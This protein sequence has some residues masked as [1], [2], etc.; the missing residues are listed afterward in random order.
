MA[1]NYAKFGYGQKGN[2]NT[3]LSNGKIDGCDVVIA[4]DTAEIVFIRSD[5]SQYTLRSRIKC[6][7]NIVEALNQLNSASDT[8]A[9]QPV[10]ILN[11]DNKYDM[12]IVQDGKNDTYE[13]TPV[14]SASGPSSSPSWVQF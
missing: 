11:E 2:I 9:G 6:F 1:N 12:Y 4:S 3:A 7:N 13:V 10:G 8:Y 5:G 14:S